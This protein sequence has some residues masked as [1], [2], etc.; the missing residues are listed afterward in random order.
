[1]STFSHIPARDALDLMEKGAVVADIRDISSFQANHIKGAISLSNENVQQFIQ[2]NEFDQPIIVCC[3]HGISSQSAAGFLCEQGFEK[4]YSLDGG[5]E[6]WAM[7][8]PEHCES[9]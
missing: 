8:F 6:R 7:A 2:D 1:M 4:V 5:F 3:Y 9:A